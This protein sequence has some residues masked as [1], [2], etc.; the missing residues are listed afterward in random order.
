VLRLE[1][2][3]VPV[4]FETLYLRLR[5]QERRIYSDEE[6]VHLPVI[7]STHPHYK[8][9]QVRNESSQ[10]LIN[11]LQKRKQPNDIL[12]VGCGN[13]WLSHRLS[14]IPGSRVIGTDINFLEI[15][16]AAR[17]FQNITNLHFI[18]APVD[19]AFFKEKGFDTIVFAASLQYFESL[20]GIINS[21]LRLLKSGGEIH[22]IDSPFY[23]QSELNPAKKR[24]RVY[25][26]TAGFPEMIHSYF[27]HSLND[28]KNYNYS[29]LHD[30]KGISNKFSR[31]KNPFYWFRIQ[32]K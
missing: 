27:H 18:Y 26:E 29:I 7:A 4:D 20:T 31:L 32:S 16:Q 9:W 23:L 10:K 8:E 11:Y 2:N 5:D 12:E 22:I 14:A 28:L 24:S 25:F 19:S 3:T 17:V 30:P 1:E 13:G 6:V 15:Q 21:T